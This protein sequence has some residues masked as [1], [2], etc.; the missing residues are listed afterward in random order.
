[1]AAVSEATHASWQWPDDITPEA[2][3]EEPTPVPPSGTFK[4]EEPETTE[5]IPKQEEH[6]GEQDKTTPPPKQRHYKP[7]QCRICLEEVLP[8]FETPTEGISAFLN[9][10]PK[11]TYTSSDPESGRLIRPCK[12]RGSQAYVHEGCLQHWRHA[13]PRYGQRNFW[14]C[15]TCQFRYRL[16]RMK[17]SRIISSTL[18]QIGL[19]IFIMFATV[20]LLGF[21]ADPIINMYFEPAATITSVATGGGIGQLDFEDELEGYADWVIHFM[22]GLTSI[23]VLGFVKVMW[24]MSPLS[25]WHM[26][27][28]GVLF[29]GGG[30]QRVGRVRVGVNGRDRAENT[31]WLIVIVGIVTFLA[32]VWTWVRRW[33]RATLEKAGERVADVHG[34][35]AEDDEDEETDTSQPSPASNAQTEGALPNDSESESRKTQ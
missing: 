26:R 16:E 7:R 4:N 31:F 29:G 21:V 13:D 19:T 32:G 2:P 8:T 24:A 35:D 30:G 17:W 14:E 18:A 6:A 28:G 3:S 12:C 11:V 10:S 1:M 22:K 15:P 34:A 9:P 33:S 25:Y 23:G 20:F 5:E 27:Q